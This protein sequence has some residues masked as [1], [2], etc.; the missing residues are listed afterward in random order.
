MPKTY[1]V[2]LLIESSR[3]SGR[4]YLEGIA[5][6]AHLHGAWAFYWEPGGFEIGQKTL[7]TLD[8]DGI[9]LRDVGRLKS[10]VLRLGIPVVVLG[11]RD[12][13]ARGLINVVTDSK[14]VGIMA[15]E[16]LLQCGFRHFAFCGL[17][18]SALQQ[19]P[20]SQARLDAF[21]KRIV[22]AGFASPPA[23]VL[24][25]PGADWKHNRRRL[26]DWLVKLP[27]PLGIMACNDDCGAQ[28]AEACKLAGIVVPDAAGIIGV[29]N[30]EVVCGLA[31]PPMTSIAVNFESA[32]YSAA[33]A[34][35]QSMRRSKK[36][37]SKINVQATHL[38]ARR[39]TDVVAVDDEHVA[40]ALR[41]VRDN[42][43][44]SFS[45]NEIAIGA[46]TS[47]RALE[48]R[49]RQVMGRSVL[50]EI[51]RLRTDEIAR[52]LLETNWPV[53]RIAQSLG[54][55]DVQHFAR[56]FRSVRKISPLAF[57]KSYGKAPAAR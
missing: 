2:I 4:K 8:A 3:A 54:F 29:D 46:G 32:G 42:V 1:K 5:R 17:A 52:L 55:E 49:F 22:E 19:T 16:H 47:R 45:V 12:K 34:L 56:Y 25:A 6:Y 20:W 9:I 23:F 13:E 44:R 40:R 33:Q 50:D 7:K 21:R 48:R 37:P 30:D 11:H 10:Q 15:A 53:S 51:R 43:K 57:R 27:R 26:A 41:Y 39:S 18:R 31:D 28:V 38:V 36:A 35:D 14:T 24:P